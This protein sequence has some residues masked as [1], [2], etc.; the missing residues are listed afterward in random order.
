MHKLP[1]EIEGEEIETITLDKAD[2]MVYLAG[3]FAAGF[4]LALL[5][6]NL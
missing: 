4:I 1:F 6:F 2:L 5:A 3:M